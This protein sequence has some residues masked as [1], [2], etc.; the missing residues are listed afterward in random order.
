MSE[1]LK[2]QIEFLI[3]ADRLKT[4]LRKTS[5]IGASRKENSAEHSW[6]VILTAMT[7]AEHANE[8][9]DI[10]R[11]LKMLAVHDL[12]EIELG[13]TFHYQKTSLGIDAE[14]DAVDRLFKKLPPEQAEE[15]Q[16]LWL[17]FVS[18]D[19]AEAKFA[20]AI[21]RVWPCI[22]NFYNRGGSWQ[23]FNVTLA[24]AIKKNAHIAAGSKDLWKFVETLLQRANS[25]GLMY[26]EEVPREK[27]N[28]ADVRA[29][30]RLI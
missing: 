13:D 14:R 26:R 20:A 25:D 24:Q 15:Y 27:S 8:P 10:L 1:R 19:T 18:Q 6:H 17:E 28:P 16:K 9:I 2:S 12:G 5:I 4:V 21:D 30:A 3:E 11:V 22:H 23:D 29:S 7:I